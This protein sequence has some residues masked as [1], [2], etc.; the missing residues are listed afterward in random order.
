MSTVFCDNCGTSLLDTAKFCRAC[1]KPTPALS[2]ATTKKFDEQTDLQNP[3]RS[4]G[5]PF[6]GPAYMSPMEFNPPGP[7]VATNDLREKTRN[8]NLIIIA[9]MFGVMILA[10]SGLLIFLNFGINAPPNPPPVVEIPA[11]PPPP[12]PPPPPGQPTS[13]PI[14]VAPAETGIDPS[15]IYPGSRQ[16][17][18]IVKPGG[19][20]V[21]QLV[22]N[23]A[24]KTVADWYTSRLKDAKKVSILGIGPTIFKAGDIGVVITGSD[25]GTQILITKGGGD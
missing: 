24:A 9:C 14:T 19:K 17:M 2:E 16:T 20:S 3:T 15:L 4:V 13:P 12:P 25:E 18:S 1:G 8:R 5:P 23:D 6:T 22:S 7:G 11:V 10:L 21:L